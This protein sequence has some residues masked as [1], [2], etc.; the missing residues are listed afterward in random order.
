MGFMLW[1]FAS[2]VAFA[3]SPEKAAP[4]VEPP[5]LTQFVEAE[6]PPGEQEEAV[7]EMALTISVLGAVT[8]VE[9]L[10]S[11]G[12]AFDRAAENAAK[13]FKF[14][15]ARV[16]GKPVASR[17]TY[18]YVFEIREKKIIKKVEQPAPE[19]TAPV[20]TPTQDRD[21]FTATARVDAQ[22]RET[23]R[24]TI[25]S[26]VLVRVPGTRGDPLRAV[27][28]LPGV[29]RPPFTTG[30]LIVRGSA[31]GDSQFLLEG[32]PLPLLYH[33]GGLT[34]VVHP[35]LLDRIDFYPGN[36]GAK[37]GRRTGGI[38]DVTLRDPKD[39]A[40]HG[41]FDLNVIDVSAMVEGPVG[42]RGSFAVAARRSHVDVV[43]EAVVPDDNDVGIVA[44]PVYWDYQGVFNYKL[45]SHD[46][47]RLL[48]YGSRDTMRLLFQDPAQS[49]PVFR[50]NF[51]LRTEFHRVHT[52]WFH[53]FSKEF[54]QKTDLAVGL[55][56]LEFQ[57][58]SDLQFEISSIEILGRSEWSWQLSETVQ[59]IGGLDI[60][61][62]P[63]NFL[64]RGPQPTQEEGS[65]G[66]GISG[67]DPISTQALV[68]GK[69]DI[70]VFEPAAYVTADL[71]PID[72]LQ[73]ILGLRLDWFGMIQQWALDPRAVVRY[74]LTDQ[75]T[76]KAGVGAYSQSPA[77]QEAS[78]QFGN[79]RLDPIRSLHVSTGVEQKFNKTYSVGAEVFYKYLWDRAVNTVGAMPPYFINDGIGK[80]YGLEFLARAEP[81]GRFF[82]FVSYT[83]SR[84][85]RRE[86]AEAWRLFDFDQTHIL[87]VSG[88]YKLG[89]G[90]EA[91]ATF[92]LVTGNPFTPITTGVYDA[93]VDV[94]QPVYGSINSKRNPMFHRL[95]V[96]IEKQ[97]KFRYW[98]LALY[99]DVQNIY[100][101]ENPEGMVYN[102]DFTEAAKIRGLPIIPSLGVRGEF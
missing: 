89:S 44:A 65:P 85:E 66:N 54:Q 76:L 96:R 37:Y 6:Y 27:E 58:G 50:G 92:R 39:D 68:L 93:N 11:S 35:R 48:V 99:L 18:R 97:W 28:L 33:F 45:T 7:V 24:H 98:Q 5:E 52:S 29:G 91:G 1:T 101:A 22:P 8:K 16:N 4:K 34:S 81:V 87:T 72:P 30:A 69:G 86:R 21:A 32:L 70:V 71:R 73:V 95:D 60:R 15:P 63:S 19:T 3:Q 100:N 20:V 55:S 62:Q 26:E 2:K 49:D 38:L 77:V 10:R 78:T 23:T 84:S 42:D 12:E 82:G 25:D 17:I 61:A 102:Y 56:E 41:V 51:G 75:T 94:Y 64:Y 74:A 31:P 13:A 83:L 9:I 67:R 80:I 88:V 79:P 40:L 36:F 47:I 46:Q 14:Q 43:L 53:R 90:W 57:F 59:L